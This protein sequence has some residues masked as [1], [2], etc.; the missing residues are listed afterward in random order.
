MILVKDPIVPIEDEQLLK[1][2]GLPDFSFS[3]ETTFEEC[4]YP[5]DKSINIGYYNNCIVI[6]DDFQ[7]NIALELSNNPSQLCEYERILTELYPES[8]ILTVACHSAVNY[9]L[10]SLVKNGI[11][12]RYKK[13]SNDQPR[14][15]YGERID[16]E[17]K[18]YA[19]SKMID[20][21]TMFRNPYHEDE[22]YDN[23]ED[24]M[25][26]E[27][28]FGVAKRHLGV[29]ISADEDEI[30]MYDTLFKKYI[31]NAITERRP[32]K[33][34]REINTVSAKQ[35][36]FSRHVKN[37]TNIS[38]RWKGFYTRGNGYSDVHIGKSAPFELDLYDKDGVIT[39]TC[40]DEIVRAVAGNHCAITGSFSGGLIS[41]KKI[42]KY[43]LALKRNGVLVQ[44]ETTAT[45]GVDYAGN[46]KKQFF[47]GKL[48]FIG[49][50]RIN[51]FY[52]DGSGRIYKKVLEGT[53]RMTKL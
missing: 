29:K 3:C 26:E 4:M 52:D 15:E 31:G 5:G 16:E 1:K 14:I 7:L 30:F 25:M 53:W 28:A 13:V 17:E 12:L 44:K 39:G 43:H 49:E 24:Q 41:F 38:G 47:G 11:K 36:W 18:V 8:E 45:D 40:V 21:E 20:G 46:I 27:F 34:A 9:H 42:Y 48:Y 32:I 51:Q 6:S 19:Y 37:T 33:K 23:T 35:S 2:I 22:V 10:Y 50:W